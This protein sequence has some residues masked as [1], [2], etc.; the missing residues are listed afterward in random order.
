MIHSQ[1]KVKRDLS[2][3]ELER[4]RNACKIKE[5]YR[6][7]RV[8]ICNRSRV[9]EVVALNMADVDFERLEV[10]VLGKGNKERIVYMTERCAMYLREYLQ[11]RSDAGES[12]FVSMRAAKRLQKAGIE[13][14]IRDLGRRAGVSNV[15]PHRYRRTMATHLINRGCNIQDVQQ[16]LG[17]ES[18][19]TTQIYYVYSRSAVKAAYQK[20]AA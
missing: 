13:R 17:H 4:I 14:V 1:K 9:S 5:R 18:I 2:A 10:R 12:L 6:P 11:S 20:Y 7:G 19:S 3:V 8:F 16:L 15:H